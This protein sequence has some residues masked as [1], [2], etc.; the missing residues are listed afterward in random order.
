MKYQKLGQKSHLYSNKKNKE[1]RKNLTKEVK[2]LYSKKYRTLKKNIKEDKNKLKHIQCSWTGRINIIKV[3][4]LPKAIYRFNT[5]SIKVPMAYFADLE[6][7]F[8]KFIWNQ[9][10]PNSLRNLDKEEQSRGIIIPDIKLYYK[11]TVIKTVW[12]WH[13]NR[14]KINGTEQ[15]AQK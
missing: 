15:R 13:K 12:Y 5:I 8:Q 4:T 1:P 9:K 7:T 10:T 6:Q 14:Y 3:S 2:D 11:A